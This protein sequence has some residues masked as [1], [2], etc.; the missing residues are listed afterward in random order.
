MAWIWTGRE[1]ALLEVNKL[2]TEAHGLLM[3]AE[4]V[5]NAMELAGSGDRNLAEEVWGCTPRISEACKYA[6][7]ELSR[8]SLAR[9][10][11]QRAEDVVDRL[12]TRRPEEGE[13]K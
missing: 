13:E 12:N 11:A 7:I 1:N 10:E 3:E 2:C 9:E 4:E 6:S 8:I 5:V